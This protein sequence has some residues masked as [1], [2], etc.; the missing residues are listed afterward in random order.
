MKMKTLHR[1][2]NKIY[3]NT[4]DI[5]ITFHYNDVIMGSMAYQITSL[6]IV[7]SAIQSGAD[8]RKHQSYASLW[9]IHR[10]LVNSPHKGPVTR[11]MF[12]FDDV[13]MWEHFYWQWNECIIKCRFVRADPKK[14]SFN[15]HSQITLKL[16]ATSKYTISSCMIKWYSIHPQFT[17]MV[18]D[19][20]D[21][22]TDKHMGVAKNWR[23]VFN[24]ASL[25]EQ[26]KIWF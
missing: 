3:I 11:K 9:G 14:F 8:Q 22:Y 13:I 25:W 20:V 16:W 6:T 26:D 2:Q 4:I 19:K 1:I 7:F 12:P 21:G 10:G 17:Y 18:E 5:Q 24:D 23:N 15:K